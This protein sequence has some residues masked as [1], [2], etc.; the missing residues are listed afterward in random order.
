VQRRTCLLRARS[1][2]SIRHIRRSPSMT[3]IVTRVS[4]S[5]PPRPIARTSLQTTLPIIVTGA[6]A[7]FSPP[8]GVATVAAVMYANKC[9]TYR[10]SA[11][12]SPRRA[13]LSAPSSPQRSHRACH[14]AVSS[15]GVPLYRAG[16]RLTFTWHGVTRCETMSDEAKHVGRKCSQSVTPPTVGAC[17]DDEL[18]TLTSISSLGDEKFEWLLDQDFEP[19]KCS[20][21]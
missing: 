21:K 14:S 11:P 12:Q 15:P 6:P 17:S 7:I 4:V 1:Y 2:R 16:D 8:A 19:E 3:R 18:E 5:P 13:R 9:P 20:A 10:E